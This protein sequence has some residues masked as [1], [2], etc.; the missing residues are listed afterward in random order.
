[1]TAFVQTWTSLAEWWTHYDVDE[2]ARELTEEQAGIFL[3]VADGTSAFA[4]RLRISLD[5]TGHDVETTT[6]EPRTDEDT[7]PGADAE[8]G[9]SVSRRI[10]VLCDRV[11]APGRHEDFR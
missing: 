4:A 11:R 9:E 6:E 7:G 8:S 2:L 3:D 5:T 10:C 1:M